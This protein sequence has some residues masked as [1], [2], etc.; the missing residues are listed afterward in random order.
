MIFRTA[1]WV[2][3]RLPKKGSIL[4]SPPVMR[5]VQGMASCDVDPSRRADE[6]TVLA[7]KARRVN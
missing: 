6:K 2:I 3:E 7:Y 4:K 1:A 5:T